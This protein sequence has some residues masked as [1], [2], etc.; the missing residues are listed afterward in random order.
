[1][2]VNTKKAKVVSGM[3]KANAFL[4]GATI[5]VIRSR[6]AKWPQRECINAMVR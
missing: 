4:Q 6:L 3:P 2:T 1:M 5:R